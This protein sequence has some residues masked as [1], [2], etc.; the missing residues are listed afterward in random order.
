[1]KQASRLM[2]GRGLV[3]DMLSVTKCEC[4]LLCNIKQGSNMSHLLRNYGL[5]RELFQTTMV[6]IN[7]VQYQVGDILITGHDDLF[8]ELH[9][10]SAD[11]LLIPEN[12]I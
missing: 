9:V 10:L 7:G 1:M 2:A 8:P 12:V 6:S 3:D 11:I 5:D 4:V